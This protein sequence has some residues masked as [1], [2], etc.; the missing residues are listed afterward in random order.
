MS[1][2]SQPS[3]HLLHRHILLQIPSR[4]KEFSRHTAQRHIGQK[5]KRAEKVDDQLSTAEFKPSNLISVLSFSSNL[6]AACKTWIISKGTAMSVFP[7]FIWEPLR[8]AFSHRVTAD[9]NI[10]QHEEILTTYCQVANYLFE[11]DATDDVIAES[12]ADITSFK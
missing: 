3:Y 7:H 12:R 11:T 1:K 4:G 9:K 8:T 6:K 2:R 10:H 5:P